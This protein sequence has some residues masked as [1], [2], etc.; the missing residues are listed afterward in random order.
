MTAA[1]GDPAELLDVDVEQ[2]TGPL[3]DIP[4]GDAGGT[5]LVSQTGQP[6]AGQDI[7]DGR[8]RDADDGCQAMGSEAV[9]VTSG[10]DRIHPS[11]G[12]G[13]WRASWRGTP[14]LESSRPLGLV[15]SQRLPQEDTRRA[16]ST[17][18]DAGWRHLAGSRIA[19]APA[20]SRRPAHIPSGRP[21]RPSF[22]RPAPAAAV[23]HPG[24]LPAPVGFWL[25]SMWFTV[26]RV[27]DP[28]VPAAHAKP[29]TRSSMTTSIAP[30]RSVP[31]PE[32]SLRS[33]FSRT[34]SSIVLLSNSL[35]ALDRSP[36]QDRI[37]RACGVRNI[38]ESSLQRASFH[39][40]RDHVHQRH[41]QPR[42]H[43]GLRLQQEGSMTFYRW[44]GLLGLV[45]FQAQLGPIV[46]EYVASDGPQ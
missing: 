22:V 42:Q 8:T 17:P 43:P 25:P 38:V 20:A 34:S 32:H 6:V 9:L 3:A 21:A 11:V 40:F 19:C 44:P 4:D 35:A 39:G 36:P 31:R 10:Q 46:A 7:A 12:Q 1:V 5:I 2:L 28:R 18:S 24:V 33:P 29:K 30:S 23:R 45:V 16:H 14:I 41:A 27:A 26:G 37:L 13:P 15:P